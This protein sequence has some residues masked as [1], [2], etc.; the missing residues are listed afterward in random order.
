MTAREKVDTDAHIISKMVEGTY[1]GIC[2][3]EI[4]INS[5]LKAMEE[6]QARDR[7]ILNK[8]QYAK[9]LALSN[10]YPNLH[11]FDPDL[12]QQKKYQ[13]ES[14][15]DTNNEKEGSSGNVKLAVKYY[16]DDDNYDYDYDY[17]MPIDYKTDS[18]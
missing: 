3:L 13:E 6:S 2:D 4:R 16:D 12:P 10:M 9:Y 18:F 11:V 5:A 8:M 14:K 17:D 15:K 7:M 1:K